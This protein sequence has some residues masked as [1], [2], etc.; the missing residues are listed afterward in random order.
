MIS[1]THPTGNANVRAVLAALEQADEL[2]SFY[3]TV[4]V[5]ESAWYIHLL[6]QSIKKELLRRTYNL[7][8]SKTS[9]RPLRELVRL[10]ASK[11]NFNFLTAHGTGWAS[12]DSVYR[13][14]DRYVA[15]Q[16]IVNCQ[17]C[18]VEAVYCY[19]D[20]A[21]HT[22]RAAK[23]LGIKCFYDL[24]IGYWQMGKIIQ[25]EEA[26]LIPEWASTLTANF[27]SPEKCVRKD[28]EL[29]LA[30]VVFVASSFTLQT[31]K[32]SPRLH[33]PIVVIPYGTPPV[34]DLGQNNARGK[35]RVLFVGS[36]GQ[37]K[38]LSYLLDAIKQLGNQVELTLIGRPT[39]SCHPLEQALRRHRWIASLPHQQIL[40]EMR[41][42]DVLVLPSL[43]EG[44]GLVILEAMSQGIPVI[45][46]PHTAGPDVITDGE[47]GFIVPIR[48]AEAISEKLELLLCDRRLLLAMSQAAQRKSAQYSWESYGRNIVNTIKTYI[49]ATSR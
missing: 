42:H 47:D 19:E 8:K 48:S 29:Q 15:N 28:E 2:E 3:T 27:D 1:V 39:G 24:P 22:F 25:Q 45:A 7:P 16:L 6:P 20:A 43:F 38:G 34:T 18:K 35:L 32:M 14:L 13:D 11:F 12:V 5:D 49:E 9:T 41:R 23:Q 26:E 21:I 46:T 17:N 36:L 40:E 37:R 4:G 30:D 33:A 31:L 44:F 10:G